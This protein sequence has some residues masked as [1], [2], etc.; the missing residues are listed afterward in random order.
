M[1]TL[2][3]RLEGPLQS[4]GSQGRFG[5]RETHR[6]PTKSGI[7]GLLSCALG[8]P[9]EADPSDLAELRMGV[10]IDRGGRLLE[11]FHTIQ[12]SISM[13]GNALKNP[14]VTRRFY[15]SDASFLVGLEGEK[16]FL[17]SL[18]EA[19]ERPVWPLSLGRKS[20]PPSRRVGAG[21]ALRPLEDALYETPWI[22]RTAYEALHPP[23]RLGYVI[24]APPSTETETRT[25]VPLSFVSLARRYAPRSVR[26]Y[27]LELTKDKVLQDPLSIVTA[28]RR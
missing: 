6:E 25:D 11:D 28:K 8:R 4:W 5:I 15:L 17:D 27:D 3:L 2:L 23:R 21:V 24:E 14:V 10:R 16:P 26:T 20:C 19:V 9:R 13:S 18:F 22:G 7:V 12:D 1:S